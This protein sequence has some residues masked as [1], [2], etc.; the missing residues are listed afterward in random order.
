MDEKYYFEN[1]GPETMVISCEKIE[2]KSD[3]LCI[4]INN[5]E[6]KRFD[7]IIINNVEYI[8]KPIEK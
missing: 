4:T 5:D 2:V 7:K 8:R 1:K 6:I 3:E